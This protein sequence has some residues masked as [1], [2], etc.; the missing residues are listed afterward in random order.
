[1]S[2]VKEIL[3]DQND[4]DVSV[5]AAFREQIAHLLRIDV[6]KQ[7]V[8]DHEARSTMSVFKKVCRDALVKMYV[9]L[10]RQFC[11]RRNRGLLALVPDHPAVEITFSTQGVEVLQETHAERRLPGSTRS[12]Y[13]AREQVLK[14]KVITH[15]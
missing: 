7:I 2:L 13:Y 3:R 5:V 6:V 10:R 12:T 4:A 8:E 9:I 11:R 1:M 15:G 14:F